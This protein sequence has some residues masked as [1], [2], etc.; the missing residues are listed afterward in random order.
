LR[1]RTPEDVAAMVRHCAAHRIP[2]VPQGGLTGLA[3]GAV[4]RRADAGRAVAVS[5]SR[6]ARIRDIDPD[7]RTVA[8]DAGCTVEAVDAAAAGHGLAFPFRIGSGGSAQIGGVVS[9]NAGGIRSWRHGSLRQLV[10]GLE[11]V[12]PDGSL[13]S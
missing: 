3:G 7:G 2:M 1:P 9:T 12:L 8:V 10:L 4:P 13:W 5:L 6:L 11:A